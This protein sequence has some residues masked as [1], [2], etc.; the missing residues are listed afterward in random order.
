MSQYIKIVKE[1]FM[2]YIILIAA[3]LCGVFLGSYLA[4]H[5]DNYKVTK[6]DTKDD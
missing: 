1:T 6:E 5:M 4:A 2:F 3:A